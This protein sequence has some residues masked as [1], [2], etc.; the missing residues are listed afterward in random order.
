MLNA[1]F[2][3][4]SSGR[5]RSLRVEPLEDRRVLA[6]YVP[7][8]LV[9]AG[10]NPVAATFN[11]GEQ[12]V[13]SDTNGKLHFGFGQSSTAASNTGAYWH[14]IAIDSLVGNQLP[15]AVGNVDLWET[16]D[17]PELHITWRT[18][19]G[20]LI[21]VNADTWLTSQPAISGVASDPTG[22]SLHGGR[23]ILYIGTDQRVYMCASAD[24]GS[25][26]SVFDLTA[27]SGLSADAVASGGIAAFAVGDSEFFV[28]RN[29]AGFLNAIKLENGIWSSETLNFSLPGNYQYPTSGAEGALQSV[30]YT[31]FNG[32]VGWIFYH[33]ATDAVRAIWIA[34]GQSWRGAAL[35]SANSIAGVPTA[36]YDSNTELLA[37]AYFDPTG[38]LHMLQQGFPGWNDLNFNATLP[39][40]TLHAP[41]VGA[42]QAL[43]TVTLTGGTIDVSAVAGSVAD[44]TRGNATDI[45][46]QSSTSITQASGT[47]TLTTAGSFNIT[48]V[49]GTESSA[50]NGIDIT[51]QLGAST[52]VSSFNSTTG[53]LIVNVAA[54]ATVSDVASAINT[55]VRFNAS[56]VTSGATTISAP[57]DLVTYNNVTT[58]GNSGATDAS[59]NSILN[60]VTVNAAV[61]ATIS[62]VA[63]AINGLAEF[64]AN[65]STGGSS[66]YDHAN[67][68]TISNP[69]SG[70]A[71]ASSFNA[72]RPS[73]YLRRFV[74]GNLEE[75][76][77]VVYKDAT[78]VVQN[79][80]LT[81]HGAI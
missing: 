40:T 79:V 33:D 11:G 23:Q 9:L 24:Q 58:G 56:S 75:G 15:D 81:G 76:M 29:Q 61:R 32:D 28:V 45:L 3:R 46:F 74:N 20:E 39:D 53:A 10:E 44:G 31:Q 50:L 37:I 27:I 17:T 26:W 80:R 62:Q 16:S 12:V 71:N 6:L 34:E 25:T 69:L 7:D 5:S 52:A 14:D 66:P 70:G 19:A 1:R 4:K 35:T 38:D 54:G 21:D 43:G 77:Q 30:S 41:S 67:N 78:G 63:T 18:A 13:Y 8:M 59:Y 47:L 22:V 72:S 64:Q 48:T 36:S 2:A 42:T 55:D 51:L 60:V 73:L 49:T 57:A 65:A 68:A